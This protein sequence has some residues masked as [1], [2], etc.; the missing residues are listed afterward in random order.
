MTRVFAFGVETVVLFRVC[1][2]RAVGVEGVSLKAIWERIVNSTFVR[3]GLFSANLEGNSNHL[4]EPW[5]LS[6]G[7]STSA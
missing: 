4:L 1:K 2:S 3:N 7:H 5:I 6:V